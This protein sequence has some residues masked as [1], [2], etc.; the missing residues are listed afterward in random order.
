MSTNLI[1]AA[2]DRLRLADETGRAAAP[3]RE[4]LGENDLDAAYAVQRE[5]IGARV[6]AGARVVG[7]K[8]GLT[9]P[10]VQQQFGV[11]QPDF[12]ILLDDMMYGHGETV[13][14]SRFLQP[15]AEGEIAFVLGRDIDVPG[16][17]VA[18]VLRATDFVLPA[19]EIVDSRI[20]NWDLT[21]TDTVADN[22]SSGAVVLGAT[23]V[24]PTGLDLART[25][26]VLERDGEPVSFGAGHACLGSPVVAVTWLAREFARRGQPLRAGDVILSGALGPMVPI[27]APGT[28]RLRLDGIG[29][30]DAV[31]EEGQP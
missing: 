26:M 4:F 31:I 16:A 9:A 2:A 28:F 1:A 24:A 17:T 6:G 29:E 14:Y 23:P 12:G 19:V 30:V 11:F 18:E 10:V 8:I 25:G 21:I 5:V 27:T 22:A 7:A 3:V 20:A 13:P 15:R